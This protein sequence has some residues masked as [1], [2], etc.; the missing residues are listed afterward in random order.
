[1][2]RKE[3][4]NFSGKCF[5][6]YLI[7]KLNSANWSQWAIIIYIW[8]NLPGVSFFFSFFFLIWHIN[9][10]KQPFEIQNL[11]RRKFFT[12]ER[13]LSFWGTAMTSLFEYK[14]D[15]WKCLKYNSGFFTSFAWLHRIKMKLLRKQNFGITAYTYWRKVRNCVIIKVGEIPWAR[16]QLFHW[17]DNNSPLMKWTHKLN[18]A[19]SMR[20][21]TKQKGFCR[22]SA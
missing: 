13:Q 10:S 8:F 19:C 3:S 5:A 20:W 4:P 22:I 9:I 2:D 17:L 21:R 12:Y 6:T 15:S 11:P 18:K 1:M 14:T 7:L 16:F